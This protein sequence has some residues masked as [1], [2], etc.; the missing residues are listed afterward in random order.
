MVRVETVARLDALVEPALRIAPLVWDHSAFAG[1]SRGTGHGRAARKCNLGFV[2]QRAERHAGHI[3]RDV[4]HHR[5]FCERTNYGLGFTLLTIAFN[6]E[7]SERSRQKRQIVPMRDL[8]EQRESAH[9]VAAKLRFDVDVVHHLR[10]ED[11][12]RSKNVSLGF[13]RGSLH[14]VRP[15]LPRRSGANSNRRWALLR[16]SCARQTCAFSRSG[17]L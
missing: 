3:D 13:R 1:A 16:Q 15:A 2:G 4:Q 14:D 9:P 6:N 5:T 11:A 12:R 7:A 10:R 17:C 8:L